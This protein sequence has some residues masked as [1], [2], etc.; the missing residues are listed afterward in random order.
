MEQNREKLMK[1]IQELSFAKIETE[2]FLDTHKDC[3]RAIEYYREILEKLGDLMTE[4]QNKY[5][6]IYTEGVVGD[7]WSWVEGKWPWHSSDGEV[8]ES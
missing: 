5:G 3:K 2:L 7:S 1:M 4:Y 8:E 6:P